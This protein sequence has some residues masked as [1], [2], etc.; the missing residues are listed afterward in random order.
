M[1]EG[2][3]AG[4]LDRK[5]LQRGSHHAPRR[6][7]S[8][9]PA[10]PT[11]PMKKSLTQTGIRHFHAP[12]ACSASPSPMMNPRFLSIPNFQNRASSSGCSASSAS[13][14]LVIIT[15]GIDLSTGSLMALMGV[16]LA[17][18]LVDKQW[19]WP[20]AILSVL[21]VFSLLGWAHGLLITR[22]KLAALHRHPLRPAHLPRRRA[23]YRPRRNEGLRR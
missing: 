1:H 2:S 12:A 15:G 13:A 23:V 17:I 11:D 18:L 20:A 14:G 4:H 19:P 21:V 8:R 6:R 5:R 16:Q 7:P 22:L 10:A 3:I 9:D